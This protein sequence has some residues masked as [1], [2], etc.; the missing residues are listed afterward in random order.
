MGTSMGQGASLTFRV[1]SEG[2]P[3]KA[4]CPSLRNEAAVSTEPRSAA[5]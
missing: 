2:L 5:G 3:K 4:A 1:S